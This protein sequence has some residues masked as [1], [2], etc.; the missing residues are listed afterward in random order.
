M[1]IGVTQII[2]GDM[3]VDETVDLCRTAGYQA[4]ELTFR[5][6]KD[7]HADLNDDQIRAVA[8]KFHEADIEITS[9]TALKGSL[10]SSESS[11]RVEAAQSIERALEIAGILK[12]GAILVHPGQLSVQGTYQQ[13]W[14]NLVGMLKD[15]AS[16]AARYQV[17]IGLENV[18][19]KFLLSPR[20]MREIVDE[21]NTDWIGVYLDTAN[22]MA[23]GY[24][25]HWI[26]ELGDRIKRVHLK[27]FSRSEHRFV[28]LL[29]GDTDWK[30]VMNEL[31]AVGYTDSVIHEVGGDREVQIDLAERMRKIVSM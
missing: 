28:N 20:E 29:D 15:L 25:E 10:L 11:E 22:M 12:T 19:N 9:I 2:L 5:D 31:R 24:P 26:R 8:G 21:V 1:K 6:G 30:A 18:W 14:D 16:V 7:I 3:S 23:Y 17:A 27:D 13:A 4:V